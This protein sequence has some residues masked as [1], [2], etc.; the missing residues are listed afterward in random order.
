VKTQN[1]QPE[2]NLVRWLSG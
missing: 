2:A 1:L